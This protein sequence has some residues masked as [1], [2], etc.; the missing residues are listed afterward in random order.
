MGPLQ[1]PFPPLV[2]PRGWS[3]IIVAATGPSLT[4]Q[5]AEMCRGRRIIA[6]NDAH[7]L[8]PFANVLYACD[9][10][11]WDV[12]QGMP[13]FAGERWSSH[14][15]QNN[16]KREQAARYGLHLVSGV[17]RNGFSTDPARIHYG[18]NGGFQ[19]INLA[20]LFGAKRVLLVGFDMQT[21]AGRLHFFGNHPAGLR[22]NPNYGRFIRA[23]VEA[24]KTLPSD[25]EIINCTK[26]SALKC[27]P[28]MDLA[29]ALSLGS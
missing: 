29:D 28:M 16:D 14:G 9:A 26:G 15:A 5:I 19:A 11:W 22:N 2:I 18:S 25:V 23:F 3:E 20:L 1:K 10:A 17:E 4:P 12:Y 21:K 27:F 7:R 8:M 13:E 24:K 6:V